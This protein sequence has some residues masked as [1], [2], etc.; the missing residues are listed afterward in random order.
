MRASG[1]LKRRDLGRFKI[2]AGRLY[3]LPIVAGQER[4]P[5]YRRGA[6]RRRSYARRLAALDSGPSVRQRRTRIINVDRKARR[7]SQLIAVVRSGDQLATGK[8]GIVKESSNFAN[9]PT[10]RSRPAV[11]QQ[12]RPERVRELI[13]ADRP[14]MLDRQIG[15]HKLCPSA[16]QHGAAWRTFS[17]L[18]RQ[19]AQ[20]PQP[21]PCASHSPR[22]AVPRPSRQCG[23]DRL[24]LRLH[25]WAYGA[26]DILEGAGSLWPTGVGNARQQRHVPYLDRPPTRESRLDMKRL[27]RCLGLGG[28]S[29]VG[30]R[31]LSAV[32]GRGASRRHDPDRVDRTAGSGCNVRECGFRWIGPGPV[33]ARFRWRWLV[34]W[35]AGRGSGS[36]RCS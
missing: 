10:Q 8:A 25:A 22:I 34:I 12:I 36:G 1:E 13:A 16:R 3:P 29:V 33:W 35:R 9:N 5:S 28:G 15:E 11:R 23:C 18:N 19:R 2:L 20:H 4:E 26:V 24:A 30:R 21:R 7:K 6:R 17:A 31:E 27:Y 32:G 14:P